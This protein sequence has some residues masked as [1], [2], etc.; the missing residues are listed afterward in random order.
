MHPAKWKM[1]ETEKYKL[2]G[3]AKTIEFMSFHCHFRCQIPKTEY[4]FDYF[5]KI[6]V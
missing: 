6:N 2:N 5:A 1:P 3:R 4:A